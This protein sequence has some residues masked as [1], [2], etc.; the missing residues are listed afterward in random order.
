MMAIQATG[1]YGFFNLQTVS[2]CV[3]VLDDATLAGWLPHAACRA[4][5]DGAATAG[6]TVAGG[7]CFALAGPPPWWHALVDAGALVLLALSFVPVAR[8]FVRDS[9]LPRAVHEVVRRLAPFRIVNPYGLFAVM[10]TSRPE[11]VVEGSLDGA[12]W[13]PYEFRWKPGD[14]CGRPRFVSP[15]QPRLDWQMWFAALGTMSSSPWFAALVARLLEGSRDV[16][17]L[18]DVDP[19]EGRRPRYVRALLYDYRF[20][21]R[22]ERATTGRWWSRELLRVYCPPVE[23]DDFT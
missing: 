16:R 6:R 7:G 18:L 2:L 22:A 21:T 11:I 14:P 20:S 10:T 3:L 4:A 9:L 19:F 13:R 1:N 8:L 17:R 15:H 5:A 23:L 12:D